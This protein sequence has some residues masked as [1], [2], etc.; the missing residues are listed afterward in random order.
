LDNKEQLDEWELKLEVKVKEVDDCQKNMMVDSCLKCNKTFECDL[1]KSYVL[2][3]Y[4]SM[5]KGHGGGF[6]F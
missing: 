6:E 2:A 5:N 3:V 4:Q 1:R